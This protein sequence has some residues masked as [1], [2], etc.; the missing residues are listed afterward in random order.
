MYSFLPFSLR[1][2][3]RM[4]CTPSCQKSCTYCYRLHAAILELLEYLNDRNQEHIINISTYS[5]D[6]IDF[7][8]HESNQSLNESDLIHHPLLLHELER[9][10]ELTKK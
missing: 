7:K 8:L 10:L 1:Y 2:S 9:Q 6:T 5:T 3:Y 4:L